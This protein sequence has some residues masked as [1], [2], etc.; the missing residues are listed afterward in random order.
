MMSQSQKVDRKIPV[1]VL[2]GFLGS[3]KIASAESFL[4]RED[5]SSRRHKWKVTYVYS[6]F[7]LL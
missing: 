1:T 2:T 7:G 6:L 5:R 3:G 4:Q